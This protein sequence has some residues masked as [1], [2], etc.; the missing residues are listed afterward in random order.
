MKQVL[1]YAGYVL[2]LLLAGLLIWKFWYLIAWVLVAA[3]LSFIG[4]PVVQ[5]IDRLH[6][7]K[8]KFPHTL[9]ALLALVILVLVGL[10]FISIFVPLIIKQAE[11]ISQIDVDQLARNLQAPLQ[12]INEKLHLFGVVPEGQTLQD[13][14][15]LK[16]KSMVSLGSVTEVISKFFST[17]GTV[18]LGLFSILFITFFF[19]KDEGLFEDGLFLIIPVKYHLG[20]REVISDSKGLLKRYFIG[21]VL[22]VVGVMSLIAVGLWIFGI[23]NALLIG[24]F[25]GIMNIIPYL[26]PVIGSVIGIVLGITTALATGNVNELLPVFLKLAGVFLA[27]NFIDNNILVPVIYSKS[28]KSHP[29]EIF[30]VII[31]GGSLA[32]LPGMLLAIPVYTV[33]RVIA[34]EFFHQF[35]IVQ[36]LTETMNDD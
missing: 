2:L 36:K 33:L 3:V 5:L 31:I 14:V 20:A 23:E 6:V 25:G 15:L 10:G 8:W 35:R 7:W 19:L 24:F 32:G 4:Q 29:L 18:F 1:K 34:R 17:A 27:V 12:W 13:F 16:V 11:T 22:E 9:S 26:G 30:F 28:V 21:V